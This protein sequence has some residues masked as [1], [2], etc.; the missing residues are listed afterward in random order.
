MHFSTE[1][2]IKAAKKTS[3]ILSVSF[4]FGSVS[5]IEDRELNILHLI[6]SIEMG[7]ALWTELSVSTGFFEFSSIP[8][9]VSIQLTS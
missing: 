3:V 9:R 5:I 2:N 7:I 6:D 8:G 1:K 4:L